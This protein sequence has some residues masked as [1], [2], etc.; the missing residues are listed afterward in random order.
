LRTPA[1]FE[2][3]VEEQAS[4]SWDGE[5]N[6][7]DL[8]AFGNAQGRGWQRVRVTHVRGG[9][10]HGVQEGVGMRGAGACPIED[11]TLV[12]RGREPEIGDVVRLPDASQAEWAQAIVLGWVEGQEHR[13]VHVQSLATGRRGLGIIGNLRLLHRRLHGSANEA[14]AAFF[15]LGCTV[16]VR[17]DSLG[18]ELHGARAIVVGYVAAFG[19]VRPTVDVVFLRGSASVDSFLERTRRWTPVNVFT[20]RVLRV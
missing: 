5:F 11:V 7:G 8:V 15:P 17:D 4:Q 19:H 1:R 16:A 10:V 18:A 6:P 9:L 3:S 13:Q 12:E 14:A 20:N 2:A